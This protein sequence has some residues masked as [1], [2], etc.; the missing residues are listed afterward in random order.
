MHVARTEEARRGFIILTG[1]LSGKGP[2]GKPRSR[3]E[4]N[5]GMHLKDVGSILRI[6]LIRFTIGIIGKP[7]K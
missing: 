2:S 6:E 1:K 7:L 3:W 4:D 5:V